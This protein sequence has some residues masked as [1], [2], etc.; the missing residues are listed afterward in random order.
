MFKI[1]IS[2]K[3]FALNFGFGD[4]TAEILLQNK[5]IPEYLTA[6]GLGQAVTLATVQISDDAQK[7]TVKDGWLTNVKYD[8]VLAT[9]DG[10]VVLEKRIVDDA[11]QAFTVDGELGRI[12][13][14]D[15]AA[16]T[17]VAGS[18]ALLKPWNSDDDNQ[19]WVTEDI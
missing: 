16:L 13:M 6:A 14:G 9:R 12:A 15:D 8:G 4:G 1:G 10:S 19:K 5:G 11:N 7:W 18:P 3:G 2:Y 17:G